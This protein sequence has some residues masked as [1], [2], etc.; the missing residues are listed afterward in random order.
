[1]DRGGNRRLGKSNSDDAKTSVNLDAVASLK[2][3]LEGQLTRQLGQKV[4]KHPKSCLRG[5]DSTVS[6][7]IDLV[8]NDNSEEEGIC[9]DKK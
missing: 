7:S 3:K 4:N 1:M 2:T 6:I 5:T 9:P 8:Q